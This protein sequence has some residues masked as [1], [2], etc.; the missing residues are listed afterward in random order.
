MHTQDKSPE[1]AGEQT[2]VEGTSQ[3]D[4]VCNVRFSLGY[5]GKT[6]S[7]RTYLPANPIS[8]EY[9]PASPEIVAMVDS[10]WTIDVLLSM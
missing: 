7:S 9:Y 2:D 4:A 8:P 6:S 3:S 1:S 10:M 5:I